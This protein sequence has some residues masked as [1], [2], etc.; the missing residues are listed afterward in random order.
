M[1]IAMVSEHANPLAVLGGVDAGGQNLHVAALASHLVARGHDVTVY[2]RRDDPD[3]ATRLRAP[4]GYLV[5]HVTAG[6]SSEVAKDE[7]WPYM[8]AFGR[9]LARRWRHERPD[10]VHAHFWMSGVAALAAAGP[11][12]LPVPDLPR[13]RVGQAAAPGLPRHQPAAADPR[14]DTPVRPRRPRHR[15]LH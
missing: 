11:L 3:V 4:A 14:R 12:G 2:T 10:V 5:E 15:H 8:P 1:R 7:L 13:A 9:H 6:P